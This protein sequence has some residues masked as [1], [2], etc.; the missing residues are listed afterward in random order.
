MSEIIVGAR[1]IGKTVEMIKRSTETG[2][3]I[4][5]NDISRAKQVQ[6]TADAFGYK[7]PPVLTV[8]MLGVPIKEYNRREIY[9]R[10]LLVDDIDC[11]L[12]RLFHHYP[13][14]A[15]TASRFDYDI[16]YLGGNE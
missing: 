12:A 5:V 2:A 15:M 3:I 9:Q 6:D 16:Q 7:I 14:K 4:V 10:G 13:I 11:I 8:A 1:Q